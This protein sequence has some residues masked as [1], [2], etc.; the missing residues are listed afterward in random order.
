M[1]HNRKYLCWK[2]GQLLSIRQISICTTYHHWS[3]S[4]L[5]I[6]RV[7]EKTKFEIFLCSTSNHFKALCVQNLSKIVFACKLLR[8]YFSSSILTN[9]F[10]TCNLHAYTFNLNVG[11]LKNKPSNKNFYRFRYRFIIFVLKVHQVKPESFSR[12]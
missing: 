3:S 10:A 6:L 9:Y 8:N 5:M 12:L 2:H 4:D 1:R 11:C 7:F